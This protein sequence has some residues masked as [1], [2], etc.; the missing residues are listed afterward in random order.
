DWNLE[1]DQLKAWFIRNI[2]EKSKRELEI[3]NPTDWDLIKRGFIYLFIYL[4]ILILFL[5][6]FQFLN[7]MDLILIIHELIF[8]FIDMID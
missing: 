4:F 2:S 7:S 5:I 6:T 8:D 3:C 1:K